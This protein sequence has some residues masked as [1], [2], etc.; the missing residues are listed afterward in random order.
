MWCATLTLMYLSPLTSEIYLS[1]NLFSK[2]YVTIL[3]SGLLSYL[4][5]IRK[6]T[7]RRVGCKRDNCHFLCYVL[8][9]PGRNLVQAITPILFEII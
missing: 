7:S 5:G 6:R 3:F 8:I 2:L 9:S 4:V 1:V